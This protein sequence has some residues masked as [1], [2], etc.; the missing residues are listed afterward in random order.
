MAQYGKGSLYLSAQNR[1]DW[2]DSMTGGQ[3]NK[4]GL[5]YK[6]GE[7]LRPKK[8][9][10][11]IADDYG[12]LDHMISQY[13]KHDERN[14]IERS[15]D[16]YDPKNPRGVALA[17]ITDHRKGR[18]DPLIWKEPESEKI[19]EKIIK[20][21][22]PDEPEYMELSEPSEEYK[23]AQQQVDQY[24]KDL[25][26]GAFSPYSNNDNDDLESFSKAKDFSDKYKIDLIADAKKR[27]A[28]RALA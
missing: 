10:G 9:A 7:K 26:S 25:M 8:H 2:S 21:E 28:M 19:V 3:L 16:Y 17:M 22:K 23:L 24:K 5:P 20:E 27:K 1:D 13:R 15:K 11:R 18:F 6:G 14:E 12:G 4:F